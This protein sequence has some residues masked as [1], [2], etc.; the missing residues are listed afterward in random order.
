MAEGLELADQVAGP[1]GGIDEV[2]VVDG[3]EVGVRSL[4]F[5]E[6]VPDNDQE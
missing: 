2:L 5:V 1:A 4:G 3:A 6:Q